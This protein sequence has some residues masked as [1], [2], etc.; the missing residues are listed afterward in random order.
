MSGTVKSAQIHVPSS[1]RHLRITEGM[2]CDFLI[3]PVLAARVIFGVELDAFQ[4]ERLRTYWWVPDVMDSSGFS[5]AKTLTFWLFMNLRCIVVPDQVVGV[6][7][8]SFEAGK[9]IFW[10]LYR[11]PLAS[12]PLFR[13][14][15][16]GL[17][18][19]GEEVKGTQKN[20]S[21]WVARFRNGNEL[22]MPA[23][24]WVKDARTQAGNRYNVA[25]IDE[26]TKVE[27]SGTTGI[28]DQ[29]LGRITRPSFN[30]HH[31]LWGNHTVFTATA[32]HR[33]HPAW[34][35]YQAFKRRVE[36]G[37][38]HCAI[39]G[40]SHK[41]YSDRKCHNGK[42]F[43]EEYRVEGKIR[44]MV[45]QFT[46]D[47][48]LREIYGVWSD[49]VR[50][51]YTAESMATA[52][53]RGRKRGTEVMKSRAEGDAWYY[54]GG[55]DPAPALGER[56]DDGV[57]VL[58]R[59]C[60]RSEFALQQAL[61]GSVPFSPN[62]NDWHFEYVY[63]HRCRRLSVRQWSGKIH[64]QQDL[65]SPEMWCMDYNG[66]GAHIGLELR[67][68]KQLIEGVEVMTTPIAS[69]L[70]PLADA[71]YNLSLFK[72]GDPVIESLWPRLSGDE[73]LVDAM[74]VAFQT[75]MEHVVAFP[76]PWDER[77]G[78]DRQR[79]GSEWNAEQV[80][81]ARLLTEGMKQLVSINVAMD[82]EGAW[83]TGRRGGRKFSAT[84]KKDIAY[85]MIYAWV[86]F[87]AWLKRAEWGGMEGSSGGGVHFEAW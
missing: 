9:Q 61:E 22:R 62:P 80:W 78:E 85:A 44:S 20:P 66:G 82:E 26:W 86:G 53:E 41:D 42:S 2:I 87:L 15:L 51:W 19:E 31:P 58:G 60:V 56:S 70:E 46:P 75:A 4:R 21:C 76:V 33:G 64:Q 11:G 83:V 45:E 39:F 81:S 63:A 79:L 12:V 54:F 14:Q 43:K 24:D 18:E 30:Q 8:L 52:V 49:S 55:V 73:L 47:H 7:Y 65:F 67:Q 10:P 40:Y 59:A 27:A 6:F 5:S 35:R 29:F 84:G 13:A 71:R 23:P 25:G 38:P 48:T 69:P 37:D 77:P 32:E 28:D 17:D 3:D 36:R 57:I 72:R 74:H 68:A 34:R 1:P 16:G 50:G